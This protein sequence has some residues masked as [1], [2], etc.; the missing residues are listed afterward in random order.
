M[1]YFTVHCSAFGIRSAIFSKQKTLKKKKVFLSIAGWYNKSCAPAVGSDTVSYL[2][3]HN[4]VDHFFVASLMFLF[5]YHMFS[6]HPHRDDLI[7]VHYKLKFLYVILRCIC[8]DSGTL[9][10]Q[11][12]IALYSCS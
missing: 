2:Q 7:G 12:I 4:S 8:F 6:A 5:V 10:L 1:L 9:H 3:Q 11:Q